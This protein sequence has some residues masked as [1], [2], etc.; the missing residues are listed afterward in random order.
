MHQVCI[1]TNNVS[2]MQCS[3]AQITHPISLTLGRGSV[4]THVT[5]TTVCRGG[6]GSR[7]A[8]VHPRGW[9]RITYAVL[10][11]FLPGAR[12]SVP[13]P[14]PVPSIPAARVHAMGMGRNAPRYTNLRFDCK[15]TCKFLMH[16]FFLPSLQWTRNRDG[17]ARPILLLVRWHFKRLLPLVGDGR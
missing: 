11:V 15:S 10:L 1:S 6:R 12:P 2:S 5:M 7:V 4:Q 17:A 3:F 14:F 9:T 13:H 8:H 16:K